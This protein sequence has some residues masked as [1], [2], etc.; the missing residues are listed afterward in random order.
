MRNQLMASRSGGVK[1]FMSPVPLTPI[2][3]EAVQDQYKRDSARPL[4][5]SGLTLEAVEPDHWG[6]MSVGLAKKPFDD[7][8][9]QE[10]I[11]FC[12]SVL[13]VQQ[14]QPATDAE[15]ALFLPCRQ[16]M[17]KLN[18]SLTHKVAG[19]MNLPWPNP[20]ETPNPLPTLQYQAVVDELFN[21]L[22]LNFQERITA[23]NID[24][25]EKFVKAKLVYFSEGRARQLHA[26]ALKDPEYTR[27]F[28]APE[29]WKNLRLFLSG[30]LRYC[31][32]IIG[33]MKNKYPDLDYYVPALLSTSSC[34]E[35][36]FSHVRGMAPIKM[37]A[38]GYA[39]SSTGINLQ[40]SVSLMQAS[41][42]DPKDVLAMESLDVLAPSIKVQRA[43]DAGF[44]N[45]MAALAELAATPIFQISCWET[46][47]YSLGPRSVATPQPGAED[48]HVGGP[49]TGR[50][51]A[52]A[53]PSEVHNDLEDELETER[54]LMAEL[55]SS[56]P[57]DEQPP[58]EEE[59]EAFKDYILTAP[60]TAT[61]AAVG[62]LG[63][64][65]PAQTKRQRGQQAGASVDLLAETVKNYSGGLLRAVREDNTFQGY[66]RLIVDKPGWLWFHNF[67][68]ST[69]AMRADSAERALWQTLL[70][71]FRVYEVYLS[72]KT[73]LLDDLLL[74][75]QQTARF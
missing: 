55:D 59:I 31:R 25:V 47:G 9:V 5:L 73:G 32:Y 4:Q 26:K 56:L 3:W 10:G 71:L 64:G 61:P 67:A 20:Q 36:Y 21:S 72:R 7:K 38:F 33:Y 62:A 53:T 52:G 74:A 15:R 69:D 30:F 39:C 63:G 41:S 35:S 58:A 60:P 54:Q 18:G 45:R 66:L 75:Y 23:K 51:V 22:F 13:G 68:F 11:N 2:C 70:D 48:L 24:A 19:L 16:D 65:E 40:H 34:L 37:D 44:D 43:Q 29:T 42:Y 1:A 6:V 17:T 27:Y 49:Q 28:L 50:G 12:K 14:C 57:A 46:T 8:T